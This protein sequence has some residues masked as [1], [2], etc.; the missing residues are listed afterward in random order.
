MSIYPVHLNSWFPPGDE[1][2]WA[3]LSTLK[4]SACHRCGK[5]KMDPRYA[6]GHHAIPWGYGDVWCTKRCYQKW[7]KEVK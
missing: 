3:V 5:T 4:F 1:K 6:W 7:L 2:R